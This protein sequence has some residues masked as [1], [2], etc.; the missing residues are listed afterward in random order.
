MY[1][2]FLYSAYFTSIW[3]FNLFDAISHY[4]DKFS[5]P[6]FLYFFLLFFRILLLIFLLF[7]CHFLKSLFS[8][9]SSL[10]SFFLPFPPFF[11]LFSF[12]CFFPF[13][14]SFSLTFLFCFPLTLFHIFIIQ[15]GIEREKRKM[16]IRREKERKRKRTKYCQIK[17]A[18]YCA[19]IMRSALMV[20]SMKTTAL[21]KHYLLCLKLY[22]IYI[23]LL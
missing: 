2:V 7:F 16:E 13:F 11:S 21:F 1:S 3:G 8:Q 23:I 19:I 22:I 18:D 17:I 14:N 4:I 12:F 10:F 9:F 20:L 15:K 5:P 6:H